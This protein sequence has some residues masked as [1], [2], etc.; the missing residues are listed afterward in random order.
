[1]M[2]LM[3]V[4]LSFGEWLGD[5]LDASGLDQQG[6]A[7]QL[8]V[9]DSTVSRWVNGKSLPNASTCDAIA[10]ALGIDRN[11]VRRRA[12]RRPVSETGG[13]MHTLTIDR[14]LIW[15]VEAPSVSNVRAGQAEY[16]LPILGYVPADSDRETAGIIGRT[17]P[18]LAD[19][20]AHLTDPVVF[21]ATGECLLR[22]GI[23]PGTRVIVD[24]GAKPRDGEVA[25]VQTLD[26]YTMKEWSLQNDEV[27]LR[28]SE[29]GYA[30]IR[31]RV[32][33]EGEAWHVVGV[34]KLRYGLEEV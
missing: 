14:N 10:A 15:N 9:V 23:R 29:P 11:E 27:V 18:V 28:A 17:L 19:D 31:L 30:P 22:R 1:M 24:R 13:Q 32:A 3:E 8:G 4:E 34:V 2:L 12:G 21:I 33:D 16:R 25:V 20:V 26:G 5:V 6:L 7:A